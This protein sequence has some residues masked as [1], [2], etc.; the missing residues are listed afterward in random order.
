[1][2]TFGLT[3]GIASGKSTVAGMLAAYPHID[4]DLVSRE[5][6]APGSPG[7]QKLVAAFG[8]Q[9]LNPEGSLDRARLREKIAASAQVQQQLNAILHPLIIQTIKNRL[10]ELEKAGEPLAFVSAA[11]MM[12][13]GSYLNYDGIILVTAPEEV[14][15]QRVLARDGMDPQSARNLMARQWTDEQ[16]RPLATVEIANNSDLKHLRSETVKAL[17]KLGINEPALV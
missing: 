2:R 5:V 4:A 15:F 17:I 9:I 1:M 16:R 14:R 6:V 8:Q 10:C 13:S 12:E 3:G 11:L 7:L